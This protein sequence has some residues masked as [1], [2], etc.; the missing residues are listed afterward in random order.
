MNNTQKKESSFTQRQ[1]LFTLCRFLAART[2]YRGLLLLLSVTGLFLTVVGRTQFAPYG[3]ALVCLLLPSFLND[4]VKQ[5]KEKENSDIS[6]SAL[7]KRYHYSPVMYTSYRIT[8]TLCLLLLFVWH[9]VQSVPF[10]LFGIS[11]PL[12]YLALGLASSAILSR[13]LLFVFHRRL[14][15]GTM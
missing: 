4:A 14:M 5:D 6:L 10:T 3:I 1:Q 12:L 11:V 15:S 13:I 8:I 2:T 9:K 7:Y